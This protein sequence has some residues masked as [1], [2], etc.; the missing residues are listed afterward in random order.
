MS[1]L[2]VTHRM[3]ANP[4]KRSLQFR[5]LN[6]LLDKR[7]SLRPPLTVACM[8]G[9]NGWDIDFFLARPEV[10]RIY[11]IERDEVIADHLRKKVEDEERVVIFTGSVAEFLLTL[12]PGELDLIYL[13][14][15]SSFGFYAMQDIRI[16][17]QRRILQEGGKC[18][19][20][21]FGS[22]ERPAVR[23][24]HSL[25]FEE[26]ESLQPSGENW[27]DIKPDRQRCIAFNALLFQQRRRSIY[28]RTKGQTPSYILVPPVCQWY[29][30]PTVGGSML[31]GFF[32]VRKYGRRGHDKLRS[33]DKLYVRGRFAIKNEGKRT[34]LASLSGSSK[35]LNRDLLK[36]TKKQR[37]LSYYME[38][39]QP[40]T[41]KSGEG[42]WLEL[43]RELGL[44]P[45]TQATIEDIK[46]ELCRINQREGVILWKHIERAGIAQRE[47]VEK[48]Y[49]HRKSGMRALLAEMALPH[50][51]RHERER[52]RTRRL[53]EWVKHLEAGKPK[54]K[55]P[56][57]GMAS[58]R[59]LL[60]YED[61]VR[62]LRRLQS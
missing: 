4:T 29:R 22:R 12:E 53:K 25:L 24:A 23:I 61:A 58:S 26:A 45:N 18:L 16:L 14:Y 42:G 37:I 34:N 6:R 10:L 2:P 60:K 51:L 3:E 13:D 44:C 46:N 31:V 30:Y 1:E 57:Y 38:H 50:D 41:A 17:L 47:C 9:K 5:L 52:E 7:S 8:P 19:V 11:A 62:E 43:V 39:G 35:A 59:K 20:G 21:F 56:H 15:C 27:Q 40:P 32:T 33:D 54:L 28:P 55:S 36:D 48:K 49:G